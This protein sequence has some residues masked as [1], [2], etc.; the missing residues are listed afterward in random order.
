MGMWQRR[1]LGA[2]QDRAS[3]CW[4]RLLFGDILLEGGM[5]KT[6]AS[7]RAQQHWVIE[8]GVGCGWEG[9][10]FSSLAVLHFQEQNIIG[11]QLARSSRTASSG[12]ALDSL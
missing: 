9:R 6:E 5:Q 12:A 7:G 3:D 1:S 4:V 8:G 2:Y 11:V 10:N